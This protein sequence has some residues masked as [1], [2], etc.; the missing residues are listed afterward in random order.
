MPADDEGAKKNKAGTT[1]EQIQN[2]SLRTLLYKVIT[3]AFP[4]FF[5]VG[6]L[7]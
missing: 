5:C 7:R 4:S 2:N 3:F 1:G 6:I